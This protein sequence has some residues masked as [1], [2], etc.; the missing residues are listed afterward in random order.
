MPAPKDSPHLLLR[1]AADDSFVAQSLL[2]IDG[3]TD[4]AMVFTANN[5]SRRH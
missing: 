4:A 5:P 1:L 3:V 2:P